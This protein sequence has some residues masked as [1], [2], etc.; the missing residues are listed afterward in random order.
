[1]KTLELGHAVLY[2]RDLERS[3]HFYEAYLGFDARPGWKGWDEVT[4]YMPQSEIHDLIIEL[5]SL[6]LGVGSYPV[7]MVAPH[8][9]DAARRGAPARRGAD[10]VL[11]RRGERLRQADCHRRFRRRGAVRSQ[12]PEFVCRAHGEGWSAISNSSRLR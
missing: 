12:S 9:R 11:R 1:M 8:D 5:R 2:V 4:A 7:P 6:T 3:R 10:A